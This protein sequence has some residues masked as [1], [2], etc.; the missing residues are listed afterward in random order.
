MQCIYLIGSEPMRIISSLF[1]PS[2]LIR[3]E[4]REETEKCRVATAIYILGASPR[5]FHA[6]DAALSASC[7]SRRAKSTLPSSRSHSRLRSCHFLL[8]QRFKRNLLDDGLGK[9]HN[10][11][12]GERQTEREPHE[13]KHEDG[14]AGGEEKNSEIKL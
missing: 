10:W 9:Y 3:H 14:T 2:V 11:K 6:N 8:S 4:S 13:K 7:V 5:A 12:S 1:S